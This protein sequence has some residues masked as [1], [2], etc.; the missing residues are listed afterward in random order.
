V[1]RWDGRAGEGAVLSLAGI[2]YSETKKVVRIS[3][4][5]S[6]HKSWLR[7]RATAENVSMTALHHTSAAAQHH[8]R[9]DKLHFLFDQITTAVGFIF[10]FL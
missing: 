4:E 6:V 2:L 5:N 10:R 1:H 9:A 8:T 3:G 7:L